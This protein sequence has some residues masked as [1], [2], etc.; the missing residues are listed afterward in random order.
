MSFTSHTNNNRI[1][2]H[3]KY[4]PIGKL[5]NAQ[6]LQPNWL[7]AIVFMYKPNTKQASR[8]PAVDTV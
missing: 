3:A 2:F 1:P 8:R 5:H 7:N 6:I 4:S